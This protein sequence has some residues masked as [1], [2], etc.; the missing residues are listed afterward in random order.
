MPDR[1]DGI[2]S[3]LADQLGEFS[4]VDTDVATAPFPGQINE[5]ASH[6]LSN[7]IEHGHIKSYIAEHPE[8]FYTS[9]VRE[10]QAE[11]SAYPITASS[12]IIAAGKRLVTGWSLYLE[13]V[14]VSTGTPILLRDGVDANAP[15]KLVIDTVN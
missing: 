8:E 9:F 10:L 12:S 6:E 11:N 7:Y 13:K 3:P 14:S 4:V 2:Q 5:N 1:N 15:V